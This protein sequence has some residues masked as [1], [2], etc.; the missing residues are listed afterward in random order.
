M[1]STYVTYADNLQAT[2]SCATST[3]RDYARRLSNNGQATTYVSRSDADT[4]PCIGDWHVLRPSR[5]RSVSMCQ[6]PASVSGSMKTAQS[7]SGVTPILKG[8]Y[9]GIQATITHNMNQDC[10]LLRVMGSFCQHLSLT[11]CRLHEFKT[12]LRL[13][14]CLCGVTNS[15]FLGCMSVLNHSDSLLKTWQQGIPIEADI[16]H[17]YI[18]RQVS[19][20]TLV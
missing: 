14:V 2:V 9:F 15:Y 11:L 20:H 10:E 3:R 17:E 4:P 6:L 18:W 7:F 1:S 16:L 5:R 13:L 19:K 8:V 12:L